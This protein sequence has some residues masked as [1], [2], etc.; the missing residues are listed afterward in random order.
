MNSKVEFLFEDGII[1]FNANF[2]S[3]KYAI[4]GWSKQSLASS[5]LLT[6]PKP[7]LLSILGNMD[8][9]SEETKS[10]LSGKRA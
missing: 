2:Y 4:G 10:V 1:A 8:T 3:F 7:S 5:A 9:T 6:S